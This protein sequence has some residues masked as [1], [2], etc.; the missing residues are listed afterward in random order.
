MLW[1]CLVSLGGSRRP[2]TPLNVA[3]H[4]LYAAFANNLLLL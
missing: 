2:V 4:V 1:K 3:S